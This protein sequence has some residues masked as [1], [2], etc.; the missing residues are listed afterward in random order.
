MREDWKYEKL[1]DVC[2]VYQPKTIS[3]KDLVVD[4]VYDVYGANG[5][6]GKYNLYNHEESEVLLG[7]RGACGCINVSK[8]KSWINGN[9]MVVHPKNSDLIKAYL[10]Y[11]LKSLD[12]SQVISGTAQ[13]Q[14]TRTSLSSVTIPVPPLP[15][16]ERI[17]SLLDTQFAKIDAL[18]ANAASQLQAAKDL[19]QSA[20]KQLLTPQKGWEKEKF[21]NVCKYYKNQKRKEFLPYIGLEHIEA[22]TGEL[23]S[24]ISS[25]EVES[26][27]FTYKKGFVLYGRLRPYLQKVI[28]AP[29]D[30][31]CST[32]LFPIVSEAINNK[33]LKYWLIS[34]RITDF[35]NSTCSGC[36]MPRANM[37]QLLMEDISFPSLPEQER[38]AARLDAISEKVKALQAN[39]DQT[40]TLCNDLKQSLLKSIFE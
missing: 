12:Y 26:G 9:A 7:C 38:I 28:I 17:V 14:I 10:V 11:L 19:F 22:H 23:L 8:P 27:A 1:L 21:G 24:F 31:C 13:P 5:I 33:Y 37:N 6:I 32:E 39:Y 2:E 30:G 29:F 20:L 25:S 16:Q 15:E 40:I 18:K 34:D 36:R 35:L 4:G 3:K